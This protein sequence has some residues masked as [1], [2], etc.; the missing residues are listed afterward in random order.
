MKKT[1]CI[2]AGHGGKDPGALGP[3]GLRESEVNLAVALALASLLEPDFTVVMTRRDDSFMELTRRATLAN[4]ARAD[5][6]V[7]IHCNSGT[8]GSGDGFEVFTAPGETP[9]DRLATDLFTAFAR[10]FPYKRKRMDLS[11]GDLD[12]EEPFTVLTKTHCRAA[13]FE[14]E[15]IHTLSGE[16]WLAD[17]ANQADCAMALAEGIRKHFGVTAAA[18][19][20]EGNEAI[21]AA[22]HAKALE[23]KELIDSLK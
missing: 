1:I 21:K 10:W 6:F 2:D 5:A 3:N 17:P 23:I 4:D 14:M 20:V 7:S 8:A 19:A 13:L 9:S 16:R 11:D 12:K 22:I 18:K 15:F